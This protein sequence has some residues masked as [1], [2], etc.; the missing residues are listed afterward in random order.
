MPLP[1]AC[2]RS[3]VDA[4]YIFYKMSRTWLVVNKT[5]KEVA[6]ADSHMTNLSEIFR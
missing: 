6:L 2:K 3:T 1:S 5:R 4:F